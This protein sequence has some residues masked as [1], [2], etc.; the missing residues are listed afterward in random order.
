[1]SQRI[2]KK[3]ITTNENILYELNEYDRQRK[4]QTFIDD[5]HIQCVPA[6]PVLKSLSVRQNTTH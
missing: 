2:S 6:D 3:P 5:D 4:P 1:M